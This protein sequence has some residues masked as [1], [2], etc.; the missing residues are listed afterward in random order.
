MTGVNREVRLSVAAG[1]E[2]LEFGARELM[3]LGFALVPGG[4]D[5]VADAST[6]H[7]VILDGLRYRWVGGLTGMDWSDCGVV[8]LGGNCCVM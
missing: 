2:G 4:V 6:A 3:D 7:S 1:P 8:G 5:D